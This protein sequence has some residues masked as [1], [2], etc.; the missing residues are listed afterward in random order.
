MSAPAAYPALEAALEQRVATQD[1]AWRDSDM[2][3]LRKLTLDTYLSGKL[4]RLLADE[5]VSATYLYP[6]VDGV[7]RGMRERLLWDI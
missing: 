5:W 2:P 4:L 1:S 7:V 3:I 6:G